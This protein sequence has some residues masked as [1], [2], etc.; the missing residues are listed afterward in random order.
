[1][2][3]DPESPA[4]EQ[5]NELADRIGGRFAD[6]DM[7]D[8]D[9]MSETKNMRAT[10]DKNA[11]GDKSES[12]AQSAW[13]VD[14]VREAWNGTTFYLPDGMREDLDDEF[15]RVEYELGGK[16]DGTSL[17][18][19]RHFKPLVI[20]VGLDQLQEMDAQEIEAALRDM[21]DDG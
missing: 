21:M 15:R 10:S 14:S 16:I 18:K 5:T 11:T 20:S 6:D 2:T 17:K 13:T 19:D 12:G 8:M 3:D 9:A 4:E 7:N 1:M